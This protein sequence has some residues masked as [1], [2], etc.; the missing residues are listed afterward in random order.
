VPKINPNRKCRFNFEYNMRNSPF[1]WI[2]ISLMIL[3]DI[4]CFQAVK[5]VTHSAAPKTR[6]I[7]HA[8]YWVISAAAIITLLILPYLQFEHQ[9]RL[10]RTTI[11]AIILG[12]FFAKV[13]ASV[14]FLIDDIRRGS[15]WAASRLFNNKPE[16]E[17]RDGE[18]FT[19]SVFLSWTGMILGGGL[20]GSLLHGFGNKYRYQL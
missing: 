15:Q 16:V 20:F 5:V 6:T 10:F 3:L 7:I 2:L 8:I 14:F 12:L 17:V 4:Y 1:W 13:L 19:R 9:A 18:K 11:F